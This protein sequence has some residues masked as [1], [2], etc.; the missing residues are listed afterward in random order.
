MKKT[1][2]KVV[3]MVLAVLAIAFIITWGFN[4]FLNL[5]SII[6]ILMSALGLLA[7]IL[8]SAYIFVTGTIIIHVGDEIEPHDAQL[9]SSCQGGNEEK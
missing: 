1:V 6:G 9:I 8:I 5:L 3:V 7:L 4:N 2:K